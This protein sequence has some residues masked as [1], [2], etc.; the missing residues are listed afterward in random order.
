MT[1]KPLPL[2][3]MAEVFSRIEVAQRLSDPLALMMAALIALNSDTALALSLSRTDLAFE[4]AEKFVADRMKG[5]V[6]DHTELFLHFAAYATLIGGLNLNDALSA[7][8]EESDFT[9]LGPDTRSKSIPERSTSVDARRKGRDESRR[10]LTFSCLFAQYLGQRPG[11][12]GRAKTPGRTQQGVAT[13][14]TWRPF[15]AFHSRSN[16][17]SP[18]HHNHLSSTMKT[19][20]RQFDP[21][22]QL[23]RFELPTA[24]SVPSQSEENTKNFP[25]RD[26]CPIAHCVSNV[27]LHPVI[28]L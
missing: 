10:L 24:P 16:P 5:A 9:R 27:W 21:I 11:C 13:S 23:A 15:S 8:R 17:V 3:P 12:D 20:P 6:A 1:G 22:V 28:K 26:T 7:L 18:A 14:P 25:S 19:S 4:V 2:M